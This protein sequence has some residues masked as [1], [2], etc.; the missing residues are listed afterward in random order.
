MAYKFGC[1]NCGGRTV[2]TKRVPHVQVQLRECPQCGAKWKHLYK[3]NI[4]L[5][6]PAQPNPEPI[7]PTPEPNKREGMLETTLALLRAVP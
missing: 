2:S 1:P 7:L 5:L 4:W 3:T 6:M